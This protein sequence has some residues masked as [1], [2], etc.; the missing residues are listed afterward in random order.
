MNKAQRIRELETEV[1]ELFDR[2]AGLES[3]SDA[4]T[5][6]LICSHKQLKTVIIRHNEGM[7]RLAAKM[8]EAQDNMQEST[9]RYKRT[10]IY[11]PTIPEGQHYSMHRLRELQD[12]IMALYN[13]GNGEK[14]TNAIVELN[15]FLVNLQ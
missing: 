1:D 8:Q 4:H 9:D 14:V 11:D 15:I 10:S 6:E 12:A 7:R 3:A 5:D 13:G 2:V